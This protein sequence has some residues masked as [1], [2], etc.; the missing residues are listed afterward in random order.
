MRLHGLF[1]VWQ[2]DS[3]LPYLEG[4]GHAELELGSRE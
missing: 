2:V 4:V 1:G 3:F